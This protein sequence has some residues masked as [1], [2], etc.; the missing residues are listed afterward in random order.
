MKVIPPGYQDTEFLTYVY[1]NGVEMENRPYD[2]GNTRGVKLWGENGW[3]EVSRGKI[4]ASDDSLLP[5]TGEGGGDAT[6]EKAS[7]HLENFI[8]AVRGRIDPIVPVEVGQRTVVTCILGNIAIELGRPVAWSPDHQYFA[9]DPEAEK[10]FHRE[11]EN[12]YKL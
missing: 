2:E 10:F 11:Y 12:G 9:N 4:A 5:N 8:R 6:Y 3:I 7:G 1:D